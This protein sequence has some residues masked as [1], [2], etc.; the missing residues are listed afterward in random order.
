MKSINEM[1]QI[2]VAAFVVTR[3]QEN[4]IHVALTGGAATSFYAN[5]IYVSKDI[6]LVNEYQVNPQRIRAVMIDNGFIEEGRHYIYPGTTVVVEFPP[7]PLSVGTEPVKK[8]EK[9]EMDTGYL[10][11]I[12]ATDCV[13]DRLAAFYHWNDKQCLAQA[14]LVRKHADV[15]LE[16][17]ERWSRIEG[18]F[19][20]Y[21]Q[22]MNE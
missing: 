10:K 12:S 4:N 7:G 19:A 8:V 22:F 1:N 3:M 11:I 6:D 2:E 13:K 15:D 20:E 5:N 21:K 17:I 14:R 9:V 18:K 16:E